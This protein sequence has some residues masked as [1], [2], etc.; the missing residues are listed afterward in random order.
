MLQPD[1]CQICT[2]L[3]F[4]VT[5]LFRVHTLHRQTLVQI[6]TEKP[7]RKDGIWPKC[8]CQP[9]LFFCLI[10][11]GNLASMKLI[12]TLGAS[13]IS[14]TTIASTAY[15][16]QVICVN[17]CLWRLCFTKM[18]RGKKQKNRLQTWKH[19]GCPRVTRDSIACRKW[20]WIDTFDKMLHLKAYLR[21]A[22]D[23]MINGLYVDWLSDSSPGSVNKTKG[24]GL[25]FLF[26]LAL[27]E[28]IWSPGPRLLWTVHLYRK[29]FFY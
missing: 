10:S 20:V 25:F 9:V 11:T 22:S 2:F 24:C 26:L 18:T 15:Q 3:V 21:Q 14:D 16:H 29:N 28:T 6:R 1:A 19:A 12:V 17:S 27:L 23:D 13:I 4:H 8:L 5:P 7:F